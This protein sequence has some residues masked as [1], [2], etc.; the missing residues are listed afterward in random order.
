MNQRAQSK[1]MFCVFCEITSTVLKTCYEVITI[2]E[3]V[4]CWKL[5]SRCLISVILTNSTMMGHGVQCP[6]SENWSLWSLET[7]LESVYFIMRE[8]TQY[9]LHI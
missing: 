5:A 8:N 6:W 1:V 9:L 4:V 2:L 7:L 3:W